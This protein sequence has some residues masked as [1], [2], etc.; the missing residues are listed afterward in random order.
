VIEFA[1]E[2]WAIDLAELL[3]DHGYR[4]VLRTRQKAAFERR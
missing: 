2:R 3:A 1:P 4:Q